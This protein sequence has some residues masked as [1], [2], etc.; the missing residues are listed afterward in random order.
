MFEGYITYGGMAG[1]D[2]NAMAEGLRESTT[3]EYLETRI[4]QVEYLGK[5]LTDLEFLYNNLLADMQFL[6]MH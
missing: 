4:R 6:W 2:M 1:R 5:R 3:F